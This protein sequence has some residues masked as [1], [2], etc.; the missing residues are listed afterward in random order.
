MGLLDMD[1]DEVPL[2]TLERIA[3]V[4]GAA[5]FSLGA[6]AGIVWF[7]SRFAR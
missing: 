3:L 2:T 5:A 7:L 4:L 6:W 1:N